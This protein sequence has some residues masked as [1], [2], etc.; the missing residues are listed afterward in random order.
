MPDV[1]KSIHGV[2]LI[3]GR[4][5]LLG[6]LRKSESDVEWEAFDSALQR[7]VVLH[8]L[9]QELTDDAAAVER[10]WQTAR[11]AARSNEASGQRILDGGTDPESG[12]AF[13]VREWPAAPAAPRVVGRPTVARPPRQSSKRVI[14]GAAILLA[15]LLVAAAGSRVQA[16]LGTFATARFPAPVE[17]TATAA[18]TAAATATSVPARAATPTAAVSRATP[19][20]RSAQA[21]V[22]RR[23]VN[24]DGQ[25]VALRA[26]PGG[27]RLP[28]KGYDEGATVTAF[29]SS[30]EWTRIRGSD[31]REGWVLSVTLPP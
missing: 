20:A 12:R 22:P 6:E 7:R 24:T 11:S 3:A 18:P 9:P 4:Y 13:V 26:S 2:A 28:E 15:V 30:G 14:V 1:E 19:T 23:I 29:E 21:G 5:E 25:G 10:F 8:L 31:G 27:P 17:A 16:W